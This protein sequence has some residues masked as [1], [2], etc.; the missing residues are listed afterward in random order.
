MLDEFNSE[1]DKMIDG[2]QV[3]ELSEDDMKAWD[4]PEHWVSLQHVSK[5]ESD[6]TPIRIVT[7]SSLPDRNGNSVNSIMMKGPNALSDQRAVVSQWRCYEYAL[8]TDVTKAYYAMRTG[9]VEMHIRRV[10]WR[11]G[12]KG[13]K[14]RHFGFRTVSFGDK[15][16][17]VFLDIV[18]RKTATTFAHIDPSVAEKLNKDRYVDDIATGG[19]AEEV[20]QM[21]GNCV[22]GISK[23][24]TDGT[25]SQI[26]AQGSLRL[27]AVV[28]SGEQDLKKIMK[29]GKFVLGIGW[30]P[31]IDLIIIDTRQSDLLRD[32][33]TTDNVSLVI[34]TLRILLGI[35]NKPHDLLGLATPIIIR[36]MVAYRDLFRLEPTPGWD[37]DIPLSEKRKWLAILHTLN[38]VSKVTFGRC[39]APVSR[40]SCP[41]II[42]YFDG[43][44]NA[45][46]AVVYIR[47]R[48]SDGLYEVY[49]GC[50]KAKVTP[51]KR[52]STPRSELNGA[53][54]LSRLVLFFLRSCVSSGVNPLKIWMLGDSEC[55]LASLEKTSGALGEY[56]GNRVGEI[57]DNQAQMQEMC[58]VGDS[59]EWYHV[60]SSDNAADRPTRV[61]S[62][63]DDISP[64][65]PWQRGPAYLYTPAHTWPTDRN[66]AARKESCIP[67]TE[68]LKRYR[69]IVQNVAL[70][71]APDAG[72]HTLID[73]YFTN[74]W[75][76]LIE[77]TLIFLSPF[78]H[79]RGVRDEAAKLDIA[80]RV[81]FRD[82][83]KDTRNAA[84]HGKLKSLF[85]EER[86]GM[87]VVVGRANHGLQK[88]FGKDFL[89]VLI[90]SSRVAFLIMLWAHKE[91]HDAR[92]ITMSIACKKA[93]IVGAK[94]L[95]SSITYNC[96][97]CRFLHKLKV[98]QQMAQLPPFVQITCP[99]FTNVG[100]D[101]C[102]PLIVHAMTNKRATLKVWNVII[103]CLNTK[104]VTMYLA[105]GYSTND[106]FIAYDSHVYDHG[107]PAHV[108][109]DKGSQLVAAG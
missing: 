8:S 43:S 22:G 71:A 26:L 31:T 95:A 99:P 27:K 62:T 101:L 59:G 65:S 75:E 58:P 14:W 36:A 70:E 18:L 97:R 23:F 30:N 5:P 10:T 29:L 51:L 74:D 45:Y 90:G 93:W 69:G 55:T 40:A 47:W 105:P 35:I 78:L 1:F 86:D 76:R 56:F 77:R 33:L 7:N 39:I 66:F 83:M 100:V 4:G 38:D 73:P 96:V 72:A 79:K 13:A 52:I 82:A 46:A 63:I 6:T 84:E 17:G 11:Y 94:R 103:L 44:D 87:V 81:W 49:L 28:T 21:A 57:F 24:E 19:S 16:A 85:C 80:E 25:L 48:L 53:V 109:S 41:E 42:G 3:V 67:D 60:A 54:L 12:K 68:I 34:L 89:P 64:D 104:A 50:A 37:D 20:K 2:G 88:L 108:H 92:D 91:N 15:P 32:I 106:F 102:G 98:Q 61:D 9:E 107:V